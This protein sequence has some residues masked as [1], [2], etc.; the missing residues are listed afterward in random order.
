MNSVNSSLRAAKDSMMPAALR[1]KLES[2][3]AKAGKSAVGA[4]VDLPLEAQAQSTA[5]VA[6]PA[7]PDGKAAAP[8]RAPPRPADAA[9]VPQLNAYVRAQL[10]KGEVVD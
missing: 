1:R 5:V 8:Q 9:S 6:P 10:P 4:H 7:V 2:P 3:N